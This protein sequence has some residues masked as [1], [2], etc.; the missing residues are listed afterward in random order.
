MKIKHRFTL[1]FI[2]LMT[3]IAS[4]Q[5][6]NAGFELGYNADST[7]KFWG[8]PK[9]YAIG[10]KDS[11]RT[12]G[13][14][15]ALTA[16]AYAGSHA[17]ELRNS[18]NVTRNIGYTAG[19]KC[20]DDSVF[21]LFKSQFP[22][23]AKPIS[24]SFYYLFTQNQN[25]DSTR[26]LVE[27]YNSNMFKIGEAFANVWDVKNSYQNKTISIAHIKNIP[28]GNGDS[29]PAFASIQ[30]ENIL[31]KGNPH[32]GQRVLID[33]LAFGY[34]ITAVSNIAQNI[35][36]VIYPNPCSKKLFIRCNNN[37]GDRIKNSIAIY[38][39]AGL[40]VYNT[41]LVSFDNTIDIGF[42]QP[43]VYVLNASKTDKIVLS[44]KLIITD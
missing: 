42:L 37:L 41:N 12:D 19:I 21:G 22:I 39:S 20:S 30:F 26:V 5:I 25:N 38:N 9:F 36:F 7:I 34:N 18:Y 27:I 6:P 35:E 14:F 17:L 1:L 16:N 44:K 2:G 3:M 10:I 29:L 40:L 32:L 4:A 23:K 13:P 31:S 33:N 28:A 11:I 8:N 15:A 43:G 24:F